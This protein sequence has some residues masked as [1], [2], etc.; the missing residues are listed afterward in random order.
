M[1]TSSTPQNPAAAKRQ[2]RPSRAAYPPPQALGK[3]ATSVANRRAATIL[4]VLAG[5]RSPSQ[6][7]AALNISVNHYYLLER[8]ALAGLVAACE[9]RP[10]GRRAPAPEAQLAALAR[11][12][13]QCRRECLRQAA[14][15]RITQ[16]AVGLPLA[17]R[18]KPGG[19]NGKATPSKPLSSKSTPG[20]KKTR[21]RRPVVRALRA[22]EVLRQNSSGPNAADLDAD[23][24]GAGEPLV[25]PAAT[26]GCF[27]SQS[28]VAT[29]DRPHAPR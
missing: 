25:K 26:D 14:L 13:D 23:L 21:R 20:G 19:K 28:L 17:E 7:A 22:V 10:K 15:V 18:E 16:R 11:E 5:Q 1:N 27:A 6:A 3:D 29:E 9:Q 2:R 8:R 4:E 24:D 12:L